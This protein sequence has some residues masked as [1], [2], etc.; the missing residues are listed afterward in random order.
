M[1][2]GQDG[3]V[4][5]IEDVTLIA[6][7]ELNCSYHAVVIRNATVEAKKIYCFYR[8]SLTLDRSWILAPSGAIVGDYSGGAVI[9]KG[10][11]L[12]EDVRIMPST[13]TLQDAADNSSVLETYFGQKVDVTL[14]GRTLKGGK[15]NT[16]SLPF[17]LTAEQ[18]AASPLAGATIRELD[19]YS[20][21]GTT[22]TVKFADV[23]A[24]AAGTPYI[25]M[26]TGDVV[27]PTF[28]DVTIS[29]SPLSVSKGDATF[30]S[31]FAPIT[32]A[33]SPSN[34]FLQ[35]N[36]LY[37]PAAETTVNAF[38]GYFS[39]AHP[40]PTGGE[41]KIIIDFGDDDATAID[42]LEAE[43]TADKVVYDLQGRRVENPAKGIYIVNGKKMMIK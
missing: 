9:M 31:R 5:T 22:V 27:E 23:T 26:P 38:R 13:L 41:A 7:Q 15:W 16:I 29:N 42:A 28:E 14:G 2:D 4:F 33:A 35:N 25:I 1:L 21:D 43:T 6:D 8:G 18:I 3:D 34:L 12:A 11:E 40:V 17:A 10:G 19:S 36:T 37:Y 24:M 30:A 39:L 20:N 32:L